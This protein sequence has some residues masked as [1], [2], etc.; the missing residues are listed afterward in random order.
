VSDESEHSESEFYY[1]GELSDVELLQSPTHSKGTEIKSTL[2]TTE[3]VHNFLR[4][5]QQA[6][7]QSRKQ[8]FCMNCLIINLQNKQTVLRQ[9]FFQWKASRIHCGSKARKSA[10][11]EENKVQNKCFLQVSRVVRSEITNIPLC[12]VG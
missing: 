12:T 1:P 8:L 7:R 9:N 10:S 11:C 6:N 2:L 3:E 5:Q 4:S